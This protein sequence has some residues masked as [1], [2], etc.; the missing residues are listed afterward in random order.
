[1]SDAMTNREIEDVLSSIRRLVAQSPTAAA[2]QAQ[3]R[4]RLILTPA[5]R[6]DTPADDA[7]ALRSAAP[8]DGDGSAGS[9]PDGQ[10]QA[11]PVAAFGGAEPPLPDGAAPSGAVAD[12]AEGGAAAIPT[13]AA[14]TGTPASWQQAAPRPVSRSGPALLLVGG[15]QAH[16]PSPDTGL[17]HGPADGASASDDAA[18]DSLADDSATEAWAGEPD[19]PEDLA[20]AEAADAARRNASSAAVAALRLAVRAP[21]D[22]DEPDGGPE[23]RSATLARTIAELEAAIAA[24]TQ[25]WEPDGSELAGAGVGTVQDAGPVVEPDSDGWAAQPVDGGVAARPAADPAGEAAPEAPWT[26]PGARLHDVDPAAGA[27]PQPQPAPQDDARVAPAHGLRTAAPADD[28][29]EAV[30]DEDMLRDLV[31][32]IVREELQGA[33]GE[34]ITRNVRKLVRAE[35]ARALASRSFD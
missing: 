11:D 33:L 2:Q 35:I 12:A 22:E 26:R 8:Q 21:A 15:T 24:S 30:I 3:P 9:G 20:R 16:R 31:A 10:G 17:P 28:W 19:S 14:E 18:A 27:D 4:S 25:D 29:D 32:R 5:F 13:A 23:T 1:M 7:A 6:V 34:R